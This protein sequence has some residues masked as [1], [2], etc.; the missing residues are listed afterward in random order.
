MQPTPKE[1]LTTPLR[2]A[3]L[4][5][6]LQFIF[7]P[8]SPPGFVSSMISALWTLGTALIVFGIPFWAFAAAVYFSNR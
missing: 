4:L 6:L 8:A 5:A 7:I 2:V 1:M 3:G